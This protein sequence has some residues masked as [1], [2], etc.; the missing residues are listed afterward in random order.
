MDSEFLS[1]GQIPKDKT[2]DLYLLNW[3]TYWSKT[4]LY[5]MPLDQVT[6]S[7]I[8][9]TY[10]SLS[11]PASAVKTIHNVMVRFYRFLEQEGLAR[12]L[13]PS[14]VLP[15]DEKATERE[16][17]EITVWTEDELKT[18]LTSF[19]KAPSK[20]RLKFLIILASHTGCRISELLALTYDD[21]KDDII[22]INKQLTMIQKRVNGKKETVFKIETLKSASSRRIIPFPDDL[23]KSL[24]EH[25]KWQKKDLRNNHYKTNYLFTTGTGN[26]Y[27]R[28]NIGHACE[29]YYKKIGVPANNFHVYRHTF[30]TMLCKN[31][32]SIQSTSSLL[33]HSDISTTA[34]YY[35]NVGLEQKR[36]AMEKLLRGFDL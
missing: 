12:N 27:D 30:G 7:L 6:T 26:F 28:R 20:F 25:M 11:C 9:K 3:E 34:K 22:I 19:D 1:S 24:D 23:K 35:V 8:Q 29:R 21:F 17:K 33:G 36:D 5:E 15:K 31:G 4:P 18:I 14:L 16:I 10:N 13:T 32:V 2:K